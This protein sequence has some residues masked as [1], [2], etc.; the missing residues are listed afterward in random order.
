MEYVGAVA[1]T[2]AQDVEA[3]GLLADLQGQAR[4]ER[5]E[6]VTWL[7]SRGFDIN[8]IR[9]AFSPMLLPANCALGDDGTSVTTRELADS[10]GV[11]LE[12]LQR[13]HRAAGLVRVENP[14]APL[15]SR[16]DAE[17]VLHAARLIDLGV[18][19]AQV[20]LIVRLVVDGLT[21]AAVAMRQAA[22]Q[23]SLHPGAS[24]RE[25]AEAIGK[26][27]EKAEPLLGPM[28][29]DLLRV[30][31][32]RSFETEAINEAERAAGMVPGAREVAVAFADLV[33][34]TRLGEEVLPEDLGIIAARLSDLAHDVVTS[35]VQFVKTIG[36]AVMLVCPD[37][38]ALL[39]TVL[40]LVEAAAADDF[41]PLRV[42]FAFGRAVGRAGDWFG[43]PVNVASRV[44]SVA[45][46]GTVRVTESARE[47]IGDIP[48]VAWSLAEARHL[49]GID[50]AVLLYDARRA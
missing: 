25:I 20:V 38:R 31:L 18:D 33:G 43:S 19:E 11:G 7:L 24:E 34:F 39:T 35:P 36:D 10:S 3:L 15:Q 1:E 16:A 44:T 41:P 5:A 17:S 40:E 32:R 9:N 50:G 46:G 13:L 37:P 4:E 29:A 48:G 23:A 27:T 26:L 42:G 45:P 6:L 28:V 49:R 8:Q 2:D 21:G 14:D 22:L 30:V 12:L 47:A